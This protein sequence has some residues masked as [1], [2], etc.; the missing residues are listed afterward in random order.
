MLQ[1][2]PMEKALEIFQHYASSVG[3]E[4]ISVM[5]S[6]ERI[7]AEDIVAGFPIPPFRR[8]PL[9]GYAL[10]AVDTS[11]AGRETPIT[12]RVTQTVYAGEVPAHPLLT[13]E[14]TAVT[15][16]ASLPEGSD[17]VIKF[18][19]TDKDGDVITISSQLRSGEN[20]VPQ[21]EDISSGETVLEKGMNITPAAVGLLASLGIAKVRVHKKPRVAVFCLGDEL[22]EVGQDLKPGK[23]YNS[24]L[25]TLCAQIREAGGTPFQNGTV[26]DDKTAIAQA[27]NS[28]LA[29]YDMIITTGGASVG[30]KD[31]IKEA[32]GLC[33]ANT[34]FWKVG[35][36]PGTPAVCGEKDGKLIVGLSGNPS[37]AMI[38]FIMLVRPLIR[39]MAGKESGNLPEVGAVMDQPFR[40][41]SDQRRL[42]R[43][44]VVWKEGSYHAVPAG[45][46]SPG[47][48]KSM[49]QCNALIDIPA[50]HGPLQSGQVV[51]AL[52]LPPPY[53]LQG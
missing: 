19:D 6:F 15:T 36:K 39:A 27:L 44:V 7:L 4:E 30:G 3:T 16:G 10:R 33:G 26:A 5:D 38:T 45:I 28:A 31:L 1:S 20:V 11:G 13:G 23:I 46:Q 2:I 37:A 29:D 24:N 34:L 12:L 53:C 50:G 40:K 48:L 25:Y 52:L 49:V 32:I 17:A 35:M 9:D 8:S 18:E 43:A 22:L 42:L 47:A 51:K 14:A 41:T 21:G